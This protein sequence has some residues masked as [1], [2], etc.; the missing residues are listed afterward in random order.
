MGTEARLAALTG[1]DRITYLRRKIREIY[2]GL[3]DCATENRQLRGAL[4]ELTNAVESWTGDPDPVHVMVLDTAAAR[5]RSALAGP[6]KNAFCPTCG[7]WTCADCS[8]GATLYTANERLAAALTAIADEGCDTFR[9]MGSPCS[10][11]GKTWKPC[12]S[13][14]ARAALGAGDPDA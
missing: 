11:R 14:V 1:E 12:P 10:E 5:G 13:C 6:P 8:P 7:D 4:L 9:M 3:T 2:G